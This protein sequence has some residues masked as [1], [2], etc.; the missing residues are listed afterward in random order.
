MIEF[1]EVTK[2]F[3]GRKILDKVS[4]K[5]NKG[6]IVFVIGRSGTGKS[7]MLKNI[8]GLMQPDSGQIFS[9]G[10]EISRYSEKQLFQIQTFVLPH[11]YLV[12]KQTP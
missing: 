6:E 7:V 9:D 1:R 12:D 5:I 4:F 2:A 10:E 8:V 3:S 11:T